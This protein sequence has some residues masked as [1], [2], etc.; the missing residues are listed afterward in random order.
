[1][2]GQPP[3]TK[4]E[5]LRKDREDSLLARW[6][7]G[8]H[9]TPDQLA[10]IQH[11][12]PTGE[13]PEVAPSSP[14]SETLPA[15][16][17]LRVPG[18]VAYRKHLRDYVTVFDTKVRQ[19]KRWVAAGKAAVDDN[20]DPCPDPPPLDDP[21]AM[22]AWWEKHMT[23]RV[24]AKLLSLAVAATLP[25]NQESDRTESVNV[26]EL[27]V[28]E[29]N[30]LRQARRYLAALDAKLTAA[31]AG[32]DEAAIRRWQKPFNE[33]LESVRKLEA[34]ERDAAKAAGEVIPRAELFSE[35]S[36]LIEVLRQMQST[37]RRRIL[38]PAS[39][40][41]LPTCSSGSARPSTS[42]AKAKSPCFVS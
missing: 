16:A 15:K 37:M 40:I 7:K 13:G 26:N 38:R 39:P 10:E 23:Q 18:R 32:G 25:A 14:E 36:Q 3:L 4:Q 1:M 20:G 41:F 22:A 12:L 35:L 17:P 19:I 5:R 42:S 31:Y 9:L 6:R 24:P 11:L 33:A 28:D 21:P 2:D 27:N 29:L 30:S 8:L 34:S